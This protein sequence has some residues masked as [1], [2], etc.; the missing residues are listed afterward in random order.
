MSRTPYTD[1]LFQDL[2]R[3][4][5]ALRDDCETAARLADN[6]AARNDAVGWHTAQAQ[7][8][9]VRRGFGI[10]TDRRRM[11]KL[12]ERDAELTQRN[13]HTARCGDDGVVRPMQRD[14]AKAPTAWV[15]RGPD[16]FSHDERNAI[17]EGGDAARHTIADWSGAA[18]RSAAGGQERID[19]T[20][21]D[22]VD[23][24]HRCKSKTDAMQLAAL[25]RLLPLRDRDAL[26]GVIMRELGRFID[27]AST[28]RVRKAFK[29]A[30]R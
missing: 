6:T 19:A 23:A 2:E 27:R 29:S 10:M 12:Q 1:A 22:L 8:D 18:K 7:Q 25:W 3:D 26:H 9:A 17:R 14:A 21:D 24:A 4:I 20:R 15:K 28:K 13:D 5:D 11:S 16:A 30:T